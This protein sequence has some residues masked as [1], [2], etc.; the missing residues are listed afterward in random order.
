MRK[1]TAVPSIY[2]VRVLRETV[3][4][5]LNSQEI[6]SRMGSNSYEGYPGYTLRSTSPPLLTFLDDVLEL[7]ERARPSQP[8]SFPAPLRLPY[9]R[10]MDIHFMGM[11]SRGR[12][13]RG[14]AT[15]GRTPH[16]R[17]SHGCAPRG[18]HIT[19]YLMSVRLTSV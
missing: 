19:V 14:H 2:C 15:H 6:I 12:A 11:T 4:P 5:C 9:M 17:V 8:T 13:S 10:L 7:F 18:R 16:G 3:T 1:M